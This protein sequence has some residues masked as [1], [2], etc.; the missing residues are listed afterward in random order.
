MP[1]KIHQYRCRQKRLA[2]LLLLK[3]HRADQVPNGDN[4]K[5]SCWFSMPYSSHSSA[6]PKIIR[7]TVAVTWVRGHG[8][9][10]LTDWMRLAMWYR[11]YRAAKQR[12]QV[13]NQTFRYKY[14]FVPIF[15]KRLHTF[16]FNRS[17]NWM[18]CFVSTHNAE[19]YSFSRCSSNRRLRE[20]TN[21]LWKY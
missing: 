6:V 4:H 11:K 9:R 18:L 10:R 8:W 7:V 21:F 19:D 20:L 14:I 13:W 5:K 17:R 1:L 12:P 2:L 15:R 16:T 3:R